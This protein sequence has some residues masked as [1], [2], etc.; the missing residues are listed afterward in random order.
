[1][2]RRTI[3]QL[4][5][6]ALVLSVGLVLPSVAG[7]QATEPVL[8]EFDSVGEST[9][10]VPEGICAISVMVD[11]AG[12]GRIDGDSG[13]TGGGGASL[14]ADLTVE[15]GEALQ[16]LVGGRGGDGG[17]AAVGVGGIGGGGDGGAPDDPDNVGGAG[18][19]G[20]SSLVGTDLL[21]IA[22]GGGGAG[23]FNGSPAGIGGNAGPAGGTGEDGGD[24]NDAAY[25][26][27]GGGGATP[28]AGGAGG[29]ADGFTSGQAGSAGIG[30][31]G[32]GGTVNQ[33]EMNGGG[34]GGGGG[35]FGGGGG[36]AVAPGEGSAGGGGGGSSYGS[37]PV[38]SGERLNTGDGLVVISYDPS[39]Q[40]AGCPQPIR[41]T[42]TTTGAA[43]EQVVR[44]RFTG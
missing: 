32:G 21:I 39:A 44:P 15:P 19:G 3:A 20:A 11:G 34:G 41:P 12:G 36:G 16:V 7:G 38:T 13:P 42:T 6:G 30:G 14:T 17:D 43:P 33:I 24:G 2:S 31:D 23:A 1:M 26:V 28:S 40:P 10:T 35:Y 4:S 5:T 9:F 18:G 22:G 29:T 8:V 25:I 37:V 27:T